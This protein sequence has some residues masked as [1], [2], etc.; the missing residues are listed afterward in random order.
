MVTTNIK[1]DYGEKIVIND[2]GIRLCN[3]DKAPLPITGN[4][5]ILYGNGSSEITKRLGNG[6]TLNLR[7]APAIE[8]KGI[9][10]GIEKIIFN[11]R[12]TILLWMDGTKTIATCRPEDPYSK[13]TGVMICA[14]KKILGNRDLHK[15]LDL[16]NEGI[17]QKPVEQ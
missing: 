1:L 12:T 13:E 8:W 9:L 5:T 4:D 11:D 14:L 6:D 3:S 2:F 10:S 17:V 15:L 7:I 16:S